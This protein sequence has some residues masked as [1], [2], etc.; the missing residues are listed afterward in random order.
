MSAEVAL[1]LLVLFSGLAVGAAIVAAIAELA[2][3]A[4][5]GKKYE[6]VAKWGA[7]VAFPAI[8]IGLLA[9]AFHLAKP[10]TFYKGILNA[11]SSWLSREGV[12]GILFLILAGVYALLWFLSTRGKAIS[13]VGRLVVGLLSAL[14]ALALVCSTG[15]AYTIVR[16]IPAW[17]SPLTILFFL[18]SAGLLG[19]LVVAAALA[20]VSGLNKGD[21]RTA[22]QGALEPLPKVA[23]ILAVAL[24]VVE[25]LRLVQ[26]GTGPT[27]GGLK[28]L[29][30]LGGPLLGWVLVRWIVG[31]AIPLALLLYAW[32][33]GKKHPDKTGTWLLVI[34]CLVL[35]GEVV[36]RVLFFLSAVPISL[37]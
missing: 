25:A 27:E 4:A 19:T 33:V 29:T 7:Y 20:I 30:L 34:F 31:L 36:A 22:V 18:V 15:M 23:A 9:S 26:M 35:V 3:F 1:I 14:A 17:N 5:K 28:S 12:F 8:A 37:V 11:G 2:D 24:V 16:P 21:A 13:Q 6:A 10:L 32:V